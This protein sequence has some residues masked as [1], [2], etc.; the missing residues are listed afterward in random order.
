MSTPRFSS[1]FRR[2]PQA[3]ADESPPGP[4]LPPVP[5]GQVLRQLDA[6]LESGRAAVNLIG[7][8]GRVSDILNKDADIQVQVA[9]PGG[10]PVSPDD[11]LV[12]VPS[13]EGGDPQRRLHRPGR[14][15]RVLVGPYEV[16]GDAHIPPGAQPTG[17]LLRANLRFVALTR[18]VIRDR[19]GQTEDLHSPVVIVNLARAD[20]FRDVTPDDQP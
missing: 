16:T 15:V 1:L 4:A 14:P 10:E 8:P 6:Y 2:R 12:L 18:G 13:D 19:T 3:G 7:P 9:G 11:L 5:E 20:R 17:F